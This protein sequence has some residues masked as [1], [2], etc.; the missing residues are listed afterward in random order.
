VE[1]TL[2]R[3]D[4][5]K[6]L[7]AATFATLQLPAAEPGAPLFFTKDEFALLDML[8]DLMIPT[9]DHSPGAHD[10][11]VAAFIDR[12]V[13]EAYVAE[14]KTSWRQGLAAINGLSQRMNGGPFLQ[15]SKAQQVDLLKTIA[16]AEDHPKTEPEKFFT[17]LKQTT[18]FVYYSSSIGIHDDMNYK[19]NVIL[20]QFVGYDAT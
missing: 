5:F 14:D 3:R 6:F 11:G 20:E 17:Q 12:S 10:A 18:A 1:T 2:N 8:T 7:S 15:A 16:A 19:G 13:A 4:L 9:D